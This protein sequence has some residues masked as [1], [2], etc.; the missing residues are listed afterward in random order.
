MGC[1]LTTTD[2]VCDM[3]GMTDHSVTL[4]VVAASGTA[5]FKSARYDGEDLTP[6]GAE[7]TFKIKD[8]SKPLSIAYTLAGDQP[9]AELHEKCDQNT[10]IDDDINP[11][12][13]LKLY[14]VCGVAAAAGMGG[15]TTDGGL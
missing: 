2:P 8:G 11:T 3:K 4:K 9:A 1:E 12:S 7:L 14:T 15:V 10:L 5:R 6:A 13:N